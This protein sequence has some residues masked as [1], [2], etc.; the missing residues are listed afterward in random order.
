MKL[1]PL[2]IV[3][4]CILV[5]VITELGE[6]QDAIMSWWKLTLVLVIIIVSD[7][8]FRLWVPDI[9]RLWGLQIAYIVLVAVAAIGIKIALA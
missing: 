5:W 8:L 7:L 6:G 4:S 1:S 3:L 9:K 2:N